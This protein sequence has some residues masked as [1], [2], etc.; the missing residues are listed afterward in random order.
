MECNQIKFISWTLAGSGS[1]AILKSQ[2]RDPNKQTLLLSDQSKD[3]SLA[4]YRHWS[5]HLI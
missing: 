5:N 4:Q 1:N 2:S 3:V